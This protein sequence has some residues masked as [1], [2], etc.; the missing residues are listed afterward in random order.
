MA[1]F[2]IWMTDL[3]VGCIDSKRNKE[4]TPFDIKSLVTRKADYYQH[5]ADAA[6]H[7]DEMVE[8]IDREL[9]RA[10]TWVLQQQ[11]MTIPWKDERGR[12]HKFA[13]ALYPAFRYGGNWHR[14]RVHGH[15][16]ESW[17]RVTETAQENLARITQQAAFK[18]YLATRLR[19]GQTIGD[20]DLT[21]EFQVFMDTIWGKP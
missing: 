19:S 9:E 18:R 21:K 5:Q 3:I 13:F 4:F 7:C 12:R 2:P 11:R 8:M 17:S 20:L 16:L 6:V 10:I 15:D 1:K 14:M